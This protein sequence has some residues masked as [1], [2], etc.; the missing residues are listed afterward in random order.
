MHN[1]TQYKLFLTKSIFCSILILEIINM[2]SVLLHINMLQS[3]SSDQVV[4]L[5]SS[6]A[7]GPRK[8]AWKSLNG[9]VLKKLW[10]TPYFVYGDFIYSAGDGVGED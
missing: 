4:K 6:Y 10:T 3:C 9:H 2:A 8:P 7:G 5:L 1:Y